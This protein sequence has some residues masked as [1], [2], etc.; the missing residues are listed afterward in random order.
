MSPPPR[1]SLSTFSRCLSLLL[2]SFHPSSP[3]LTG[4]LSVLYSLSLSH[5]SSLTPSL[6]LSCTHTFTPSLS[7][8]FCLTRAPCFSLGVRLSHSCPSHSFA[9]CLS[10]SLVRSLSRC[11]SH[12]L[13]FLYSLHLM[14]TLH[15]LP[16]RPHILW[17]SQPLH[18]CVSCM[19]RKCVPTYIWQPVTGAR[20]TCERAPEARLE[21]AFALH[22]STSVPVQLHML[23]TYSIAA[24]SYC[25]KAASSAET[26]S[27]IQLDAL[28]AW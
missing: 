4:C 14:L 10:L 15:T 16:S 19:Q 5:Y 11:L 7:H 26:A 18:R 28:V 27:G 12:S 23:V 17:P 1:C 24:S 6:S 20:G 8:S 2:Y 25:H 13:S 21:L 22:C 9:R 3:S